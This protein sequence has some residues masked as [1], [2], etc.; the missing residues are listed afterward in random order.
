MFPD[1]MVSFPD[2]M[3]V[4]PDFGLG[5]EWGLDDTDAISYMVNRLS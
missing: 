2:F 3:V 1:F 4:F 5:S